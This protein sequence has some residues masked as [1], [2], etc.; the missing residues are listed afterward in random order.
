MIKSLFS[1]KLFVMAIAALFVSSAFGVNVK[2][3]A[4]PYQGPTQ[5]ILT[6]VITSNY[7]KSRLLAELIQN[8]T[9]QPIL[10][11]PAGDQKGIYFM[12]KYG[13]LAQ[14]ITEDQFG[15]FIDFVNPQKIV[16]LGDSSFVPRKYID[17]IDK[18][19]VVVQVNSKD[20]LANAKAVSTILDLHNLAY[21]YTRLY[22]QVEGGK[23]YSPTENKSVE[24]KPIESNLAVEDNGAV[25]AKDEV[26][27]EVKPEAK[28]EVTEPMV[29]AA[30]VK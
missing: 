19:M 2:E 28:A 30:P 16:V 17:Q 5:D 9:K 23:L 20:W 14:E 18:K 29:E 21:D 6:L 11:L 8:A 26:K 10:L 25:E 1:K 12:P 24:S 13:K 7:K 4:Q 27:L 15:R 22:R 3:L